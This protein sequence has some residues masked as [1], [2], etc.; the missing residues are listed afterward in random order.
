MLTIPTISEW[1]SL[2]APPQGELFGKTLESWR[3][4]A[5]TTLGITEKLIIVVGHQPEF[6]HPGVLAKFVAASQIAKQTS[7]VLVHLV[8]DHHIGNA[9]VI[10]MPDTSGQY[11]STKQMT[12]ATLDSKIAMKDQPRAEPVSNTVFSDALGKAAGENAAMQFAHATDDLMASMANVDYCI[13][14]T[15][16]LTTELGKAIVLEMKTNPEPCI[17]AY[18]NAIKQFPSCGI[19]LLEQN[20][21]PIWRG[22][23]NEKV[24][25][26]FDDLRP[27]ALLLTLL[28]R[29]TLGDLFVHG[30]SGYEYDKVMEHW[31]LAWLD[32]KPCA[33]VMATETIVLPLQTQSIEQA[34]REYF[35][36]P[37]H[38][39]NAI[40]GAPYG[41]PE[42]KLHF[43][44]LHKWLEQLHAKPDIGALKNARQIANR[45][46][47]AFPLYG[48]RLTKDFLAAKSVATHL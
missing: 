35:R 28:A 44:A 11:L 23:T 38:F 45:R 10:E 17:T 4:S 13:A 18:N 27:R 43:L 9:G 12:I 20:E 32:V 39:L 40:N 36:A 34:R 1:S 41:S 29:L 30:M 5:R 21:L 16:L 2:V 37:A 22:K 8:V 15:S 47:W 48:E 33:M 6:F 3:T 25:T 46:D 26:E 42:R 19:S 7:S 31:L 24:T 14:G